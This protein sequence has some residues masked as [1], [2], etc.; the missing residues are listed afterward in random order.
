MVATIQS[1]NGNQYLAPGVGLTTAG[2]FVGS[3]ASGAINRVTNQ[4]ICAPILVNGLKENKGADTNTIR[5]ALETALDTTGMKDKG[6]TIK[7]Y[8][9][10]KSSDVKSRDRLIKEFL[11]RI[12]KR[13]EKVSISDIVNAQAKEQAKLGVNALYADKAVHVNIDKAGILAFHELGHAINEN[14][15]KFWKMMQHSRKLMGLVVLP[16]LPVIAM[17]KRKKVEG[18]KTTGPVDKVTT[19]I[20]ENVGK[21]STLAFVPVIVEEFKATARGNK[22]AKELLSPELVS[23]VAKCNRMGGLTYV[24]LGISTGIGAFTAN[25]IK[26]AIAKPE[27]V[28]NSEV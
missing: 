2:Y 6:I 17:C 28:K 13:K 21:L 27:L 9:G 7:D 4:V 12:I 26:D 3:M 1:S 22:L 18:E 23:K 15:S 16:S 10:C 20:K 5:K 19:F 14:G 8:S 25:K 24:A 11:V